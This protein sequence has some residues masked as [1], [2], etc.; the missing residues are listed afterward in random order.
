MYVLGGND[1]SE[2]FG[3][4]WR[5][6]LTDIVNYAD[7]QWA[8]ENKNNINQNNAVRGVVGDN[9]N[10]LNNNADNGGIIRNKNNLKNGSND[11]KN[12]ENENEKENEVKTFIRPVWE[13]LS[14]NCALDG[15]PI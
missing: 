11:S 4:F 15:K 12:S 1:I 8:M 2:T 7:Q 9:K 13:R 14:R 10:D 3:D 5:I 6:S